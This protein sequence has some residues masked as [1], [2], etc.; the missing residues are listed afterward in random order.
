MKAII[1]LIISTLMLITSCTD[2][3]MGKI[4]SL[5]SKASVKCYSGNLLIYEGVSTGKV[6]SSEQ[7]DGYYFV[8]SADGKLKEVSGNCIITYLN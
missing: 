2:A 4:T 8:D 6:K 1:L 3:W 5:G 7:S